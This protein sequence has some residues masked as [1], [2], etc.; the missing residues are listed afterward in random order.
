MEN[1]P[2][3]VVGTRRAY[4]ESVRA[5]IE[6][7]V[8]LGYAVTWRVL[9]GAD[10]GVPQN[11]RRL[12]MVGLRSACFR[13]PSPSHGP[14][15]GTPHVASGSVVTPTRVVGHPNPSIVTYAKRPDLRPSP[16]DGHVYNGGGR[17]IDLA[18]PCH[19]I[20][21]SAGGNKTH[22][23]DGGDV[24]QAYHAHLLA[25]D[26]PREGVVPGARRLTVTES[27]ML[28]TFPPEVVFHGSRSS[29]Y[30]QVGNAVP[31]LLAR[32]LGE[33]IRAQLGD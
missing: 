14:E 19:T 24:V 6:A 27:A 29:Q 5:Q 21:A 23:L 11:R 28:Q 12:F 2:G 25:G 9:N 20:L 18:R 4:L 26:G 8:D 32:V 10:Y 15:V 1:V 17:P 22:W 3:L 13:F 7:L 31:V 33:A 30:S 16:Y